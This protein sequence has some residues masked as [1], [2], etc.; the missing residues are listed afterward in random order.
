M[1]SK[2]PYLALRR[3]GIYYAS[4]ATNCSDKIIKLGFEKRIGSCTFSI[5]GFGKGSYT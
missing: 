4:R 2:I 3:Y 5:C 1:S